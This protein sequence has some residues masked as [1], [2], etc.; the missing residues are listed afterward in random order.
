[1]EGEK[2]IATEKPD[3]T[4]KPPSVV[5]AGVS[6]AESGHESSGDADPPENACNAIRDPEEP[7]DWCDADEWRT[8]CRLADLIEAA[9]TGAEVVGRGEVARA[10]H[11]AMLLQDAGKGNV[12]RTLRVDCIAA[13]EKLSEGRWRDGP[14][15]SEIMRAMQNYPDGVYPASAGTNGGKRASRVEEAFRLLATEDRKVAPEFR[16]KRRSNAGFQPIGDTMGKISRK[17]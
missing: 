11:I 13:I 4:E 3:A 14:R 15:P 7:P 6:A 16:G 17:P 9:D 5:A 8:A 12:L 1:M 2:S 10:W